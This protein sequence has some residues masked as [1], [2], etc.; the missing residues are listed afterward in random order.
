M[1]NYIK[2]LEP[3]FEHFLILSLFGDSTLNTMNTSESNQALAVFMKT[4]MYHA[5]NSNYKRKE[6][7]GTLQA[8]FFLIIHLINFLLKIRKIRFI[9]WSL[10]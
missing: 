7:R 4:V 5:V 1:H 3:Y 9:A 10:M 6:Y 8:L 2:I